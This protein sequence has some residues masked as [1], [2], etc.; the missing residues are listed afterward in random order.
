MAAASRKKPFTHFRSTQDRESAPR[1]IP[2]AVHE[3]TKVRENDAVGCSAPRPARGKE[4]PED[5]V[6]GHDDDEDVERLHLSPGNR[7]PPLQEA[8]FAGGTLQV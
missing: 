4:A 5:L 7:C 2:D 1:R 8:C 6:R 3:P